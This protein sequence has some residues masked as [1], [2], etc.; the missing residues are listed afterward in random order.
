[1]LGLIHDVGIPLINIGMPHVHDHH[2]LADSISIFEFGF[3]KF[4]ESVESAFEAHF[5]PPYF[6]AR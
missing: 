6:K 4:A 5:S 2:K 1:M 3:T